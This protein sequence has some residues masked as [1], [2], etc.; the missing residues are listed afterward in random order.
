MSIT[1]S[2]A[3]FSA[4]I[5]ETLHTRLELL[6]AETEESMARTVRYLLLSLVALFFASVGVLLLVLLAVV[7]FWDTHRELV[8]LSMAFGFFAIAGGILLWIKTAIA[9]QPKFL[10]L[11]IQEL[12]SDVAALRGNRT[13]N[14]NNDQESP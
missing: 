10:E 9:N 5:I 1:D 4:S 12:R 11:T 3:R 6:S 7:C 13:S 14:G 2:L 8:I